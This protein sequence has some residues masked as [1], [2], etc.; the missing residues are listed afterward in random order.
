MAPGFSGSLWP[1]NDLTTWR[2]DCQVACNLHDPR[3]NDCLAANVGWCCALHLNTIRH[4]CFFVFDLD[5]FS[6]SRPIAGPNMSYPVIPSLIFH[7]QESKRGQV[8][9]EGRSLSDN[10]MIALVPLLNPWLR[11][12]NCRTCGQLGCK[13]TFFLLSFLC[14]VHPFATGWSRMNHVCYILGGGLEAFGWNKSG[15][16]WAEPPVESSQDNVPQP[17]WF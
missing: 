7:N 1:S 8:W 10:P 4:F 2:H 14:I 11:F 5:W 6:I 15:Q 16:K 3:R 13:M 12:C 9:D 17:I